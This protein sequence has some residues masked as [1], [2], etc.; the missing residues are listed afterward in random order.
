MISLKIK[1]WVK[2]WAGK[3]RLLNIVR[4]EIEANKSSKSEGKEVQI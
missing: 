3:N 1:D 2:K 4:F